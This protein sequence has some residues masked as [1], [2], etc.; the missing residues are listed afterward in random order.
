MY[1]HGNIL[2]N[3]RGEC[4]EMKIGENVKRYRKK[5]G[6]TQKD[7]AKKLSVSAAAVSQF[8]SAES[9]NYSTI[10]KIAKALNINPYYLITGDDSKKIGEWQ[11]TTQE[12]RDWLEKESDRVLLQKI[13][14]LPDIQQAALNV[15]IEGLFN[16]QKKDPEQ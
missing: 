7:L 9:L 16:N 12:E 8:E 14:S 2:L 4:D 11:P 3:K 1:F 13:K 15:I 10:E 5:A 6:L